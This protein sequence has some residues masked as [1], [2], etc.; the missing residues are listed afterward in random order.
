LKKH[1]YLFVRASYENTDGMSSRQQMG[2]G[3][4]WDR[5]RIRI[6]G[7]DDD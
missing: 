4:P 7:G 3:L 1:S 2:C 5:M 6:N